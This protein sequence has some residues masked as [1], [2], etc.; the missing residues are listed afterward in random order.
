MGNRTSEHAVESTTSPP[1]LAQ[2]ARWSQELQH[3]FAYF[4]NPSAECYAEKLAYML[5]RVEDFDRRFP[6]PGSDDLTGA[7]LLEFLKLEASLASL[8]K[9]K[10]TVPDNMMYLMKKWFAPPLTPEERVSCMA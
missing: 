6:P 2:L 5:R 3:Y 4:G 9:V 7:E 8:R 10:V 1:T